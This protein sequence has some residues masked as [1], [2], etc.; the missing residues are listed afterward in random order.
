MFFVIGKCT[1][2][3]REKSSFR[4]VITFYLILLDSNLS[5]SSVKNLKNWKAKGKQHVL[6]CFNTT[7]V[8]DSCVNVL[9]QFHLCLLQ[10]LTPS[11]LFTYLMTIGHFL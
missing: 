1:E 6:L 7:V 4:K 10:Y 8:V 9:D 5:G 3:K 2:S 11:L